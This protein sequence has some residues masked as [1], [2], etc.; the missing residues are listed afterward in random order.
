ML[1]AARPISDW[2]V[3]LIPSANQA[4]QIQRA[5]T[6]AVGGAAGRSETA[7]RAI[8]AAPM[9]TYVCSSALD[10]GSSVPLTFLLDAER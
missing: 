6:D 2:A 8:G 9:K 4:I 1:V 7:S 3:H 5:R 10:A